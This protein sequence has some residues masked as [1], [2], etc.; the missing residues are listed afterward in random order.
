MLQ[1][2]RLGEKQYNDKKK[3]TKKQSV[4]YFHKSTVHYCASFTMCHQINNPE[5]AI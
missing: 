4:L 1:N 5:K 2:T 3:E